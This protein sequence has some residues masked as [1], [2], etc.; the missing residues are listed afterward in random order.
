MERLKLQIMS[1][2]N[3]LLRWSAAVLK[4]R[5][6]SSCTSAKNH[7]CVPFSCQQFQ[8]APHIS[9]TIHTKTCDMGSADSAA[10]PK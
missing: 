2:L 4:P 7:K 5:P 10:Q 9:I 3:I 1:Q 6:K 8:L